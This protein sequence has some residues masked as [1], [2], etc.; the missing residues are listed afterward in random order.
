MP[1]KIVAVL[2]A[3]HSAVG[4]ILD[5]AQAQES[6]AGDADHLGAARRQRRRSPSAAAP[7]TSLPRAASSARSLP[8]SFGAGGVRVETGF[9]LTHITSA[10]ATSCDW[11]RDRRA[12]AA[13]L[14]PTS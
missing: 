2:G 1:N 6:R 10:M 9:R 4:T 13:M 12:A 14:R 11:V 5:L 8:S 7:T 3:G